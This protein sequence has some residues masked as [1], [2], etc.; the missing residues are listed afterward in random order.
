MWDR[1][2]DLLAQSVRRHLRIVDA[3]QLRQAATAARLAGA[4]M[5]PPEVLA[6]HLLRVRQE[7]TTASE[8]AAVKD[9]PRRP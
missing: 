6:F 3:E 5:L 8:G 9:W 2:H 7:P 4:A 1:L